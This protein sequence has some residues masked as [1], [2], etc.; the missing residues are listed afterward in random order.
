MIFETENG[1]K[2][3]LVQDT[4]TTPP[5]KEAI[6]GCEKGNIVWRSC[7]HKGYDEVSIDTLN[8]GENY[9]NKVFPKASGE[10]AEMTH[11][12]FI[13]KFHRK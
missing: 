11:K 2:G 6:I 9:Y 8:D 5:I 4:L 1:L 3:R 12:Q 7:G 10:T 13:Y